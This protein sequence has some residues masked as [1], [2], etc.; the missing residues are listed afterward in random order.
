M[1]SLR[2]VAAALVAGAPL[3]ATAPYRPNPSTVTYSNYCLGSSF[4][5]C[6]SVQVVTVPNGQGGTTVEIR[7]RVLDNGF[8]GF[9]A[10]GS[11]TNG[12][13][14]DPIGQYNVGRSYGSIGAVNGRPD[15]TDDAWDS[16]RFE[17]F[18]AIYGCDLHGV[19][20]NDPNG[21]GGFQTCD[22]LGYTGWVVFRLDFTTVLNPRSL[23]VEWE[24]DGGVSGECQLSQRQP[25][26]GFGCVAGTVT[27]TPEP[28]TWALVGTGIL[29]IVLARRV[30]RTARNPG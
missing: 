28:A 18:P 7:T 26:P 30:R 19:D 4:V 5:T 10:F 27:A 23:F 9:M 12:P 8:I 22:R 15:P 29:G 1:H 2:V 17:W 14:L 11:V 21:P 20:L 25:N 6:A 3:S 24:S 13:G 16:D